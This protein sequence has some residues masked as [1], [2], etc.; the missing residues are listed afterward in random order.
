MVQTFPLFST[1][2][3]HKTFELVNLIDFSTN[4]LFK[5]LNQ[6]CF[7]S[8]CFGERGG[9]EI[10]RD[11]SQ[12]KKTIRYPNLIHVLWVWLKFI[13]PL[14]E[15]HVPFQKKKSLTNWEHLKLY[16]LSD[17]KHA[18]HLLAS[19]TN[20]RPS[21]NKSCMNQNNKHAVVTNLCQLT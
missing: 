12:N 5:K 2:E 6:S 18:F 4:G 21:C 20:L 16:T 7:N 13:L 1:Y 3:T 14:L 17:A 11:A 8:F 19:G 10:D 9:W 15:L